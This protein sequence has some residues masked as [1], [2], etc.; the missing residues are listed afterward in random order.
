MPPFSLQPSPHV[1]ERR[2]PK[3]V[4]VPPG[5]PWQLSRA[6]G[7]RWKDGQ[8]L[9]EAPCPTVCALIE[10]KTVYSSRKVVKLSVSFL[11]MSLLHSSPTYFPYPH[12]NLMCQFIYSQGFYFLAEEIKERKEHWKRSC[13]EACD[14][15]SLQ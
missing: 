6:M 1:W 9:R 14:F 15:F 13:N 11:N 2:K 10:T 5:F 3:E 8:A 7:G 4:P 12:C